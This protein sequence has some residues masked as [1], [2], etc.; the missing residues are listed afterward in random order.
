MKASF[1]VEPFP[2]SADYK[3]IISGA[4]DDSLKPCKIKIAVNSTTV[5]EGASPFSSQ[6]WSVKEFKVPAAALSQF[7]NSTLTVSNMED[8]D[9]LSGP[10]FFLLN[11]ALLR[12]TAE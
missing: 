7:R 3:L 11:Y 6:K 1:T 4:N 5:F 2:P 12:K 8:T 9:N 10:P